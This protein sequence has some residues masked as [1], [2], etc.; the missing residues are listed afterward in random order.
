MPI[1][2]SRFLDT[3]RYAYSLSLCVCVSC[4]LHSLLLVTRSC[5]RCILPGSTVG[6][7]EV[8]L[9]KKSP[10]DWPELEGTATPAARPAAAP[11]TSDAS[12]AAIAPPVEEPPTKVARPYSSTKNWDVVSFWSLL[13]LGASDA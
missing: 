6:Q 5:G 1:R 8:T 7:L 11:T 9:T 12:S 3:P 2:S 10:A 4:S 13:L